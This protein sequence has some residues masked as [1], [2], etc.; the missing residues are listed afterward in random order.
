MNV[1]IIN[2]EFSEGFV[3]KYVKNKIQP[4]CCST[5]IMVSLK[6]YNKLN[7]QLNTIHFF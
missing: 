3:K 4:D 2:T 6:V 7:I 5:E 1:A